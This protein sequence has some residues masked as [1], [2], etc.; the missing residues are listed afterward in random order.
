MEKSVKGHTVKTVKSK[1]YEIKNKEVKFDG[2][3]EIIQIMRKR[4][5]LTSNSLK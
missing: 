5:I 3:Y 1:F 4:F 2:L